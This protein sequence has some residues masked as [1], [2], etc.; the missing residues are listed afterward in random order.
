MMIRNLRPGFSELCCL[1]VMMSAVTLPASALASGT[2]S[3]PSDAKSVVLNASRIGATPTNQII[4]LA[5][6]LPSR[7]AD[8]AA[9]FVAHVSKL[10]DK[11]FRHYLTPM[12]YAT[13][14]GAKIEDYRAVVAWAKAQGLTTGEEFAAH[15][16]LPV[17]GPASAIEAAFGVKLS[18][19]RDAKG[20]VFFSADSTPVL[21]ADISSHISAVLGLSSANHFA[22]LARRAPAGVHLRATGTGPGG[23]YSAADLRTAYL[24]PKDATP[25]RSEVV[26][27][28]EQGGFDP[29]DVR[30]Y[31]AANNLTN[32]PVTARSVDGYGGGIDDPG[33]ELEAVLD[34][35]MMIAMNPAEKQVLVYENGSDSFAV[36]MIDSFAAMA[37]DNKAQTI[38]VSYGLDEHMQAPATL[39]AEK[40][41]LTQ[42]AAQGQTVFASAGDNGAYGLELN[43]LNVSDPASQS[44]VVS[45]G[46]TS[47]FTD[48][49]QKYLGE[50]TWNDL[51]LELGATGGGVSSVWNIPKWQVQNGNS[52]ATFNGG[53][54]TMR[55]VPDVAAVADPLTPVAVY[56]A[57]NGGWI[58]IGGTS[59]SSPL[60]AGYT[61]VVNSASKLL[62]FG[63]LGFINPIL[64]Q[65]GYNGMFSDIGDGSNGNQNI[66][67]FPGFNAGL[68]YDNATGWGSMR[69]GNM[70][71]NVVL[72]RTFGNRNPPPAPNGLKGKLTATGGFVK[73]AA[74]PGVNG[75]Y[76]LGIDDSGIE[77]VPVFWFITKGTDAVVTG[78]HPNT[79]YSFIVVSITAGGTTESRPLVLTTPA[80]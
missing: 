38:S 43:A 27:V 77:S 40:T 18:N 46:G 31:L 10:G 25:P 67:G 65:F 54:A 70:E 4:S 60:W 63:Q 45:V 15:L 13:Q 71:L 34:I 69:G 12:Q 49:Q 50:V 80:S 29:N 48:P 28:F 16:V 44:L 26:A 2:V 1:I 32:V 19:Y 5:V 76:C 37:T 14:F 24:I 68:T 64:Y 23:G 66:F 22:S 57:I 72:A 33:I 58:P 79:L 42:L 51:S 9:S 7:N 61:S 39:K 20:R 30:T 73:W 74:V 78:L 11:L 41:V 8:G 47:L 62:G 56:S 21:S 53:S 52:V 35:D 17:S 59:V 3:V 6:I 36:A 75:Y 55:N